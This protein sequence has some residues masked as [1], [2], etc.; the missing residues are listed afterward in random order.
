M[1]MQPSRRRVSLFG[2]VVMAA[3]SLVGAGV[4]PSRGEASEG[5]AAVQATTTPKPQSCAPG[6]RPETG[7]QGQVPPAD[8]HSGRSHNGYS[9]NLERIGG[10]S[11]ASFANFDSYRNCAYYT[12]NRGGSGM[13][14]GGGVVVDLSDPALPVKT[15]HLKAMAMGNGGESLRVN[16]ARGLLVSDH[17]NSLQT[18]PKASEYVHSLAVYDLTKDCRHPELLA[19]VVMPRAEGHEGCFQPDG[20]VYYMASTT[21]ITPIDLTDPRR[22]VELTAP[23]PLSIH[24]CS[25]SDDGRRGYFSDIGAARTLVVD[26]SEVQH[27]EPGAGYRII[28]TFDTPDNKIKQ[29]SHPLRYGDHQYLFDWSELTGNG[30]GGCRPGAASFGYASMVDIADETKPVEVSRLM[31]E[32][33]DPANCGLMATDRSPQT[34]GLEHGDVFFPAAAQLFTYD[35][36]YCRPDRLHEPTIM[37]CANFASGVRV[38]DIRDP[39]APKEI[40]Y[41]NTGTVP[42]PQPVAD[43]AASPPVIRRDLGQIWWVTLYG[44]LHV[45]Q[46]RPGVWPFAG[47]PAC[48]SPEDYFAVQYGSCSPPVQAA[49]APVAATPTTATRTAATPPA[50]PAAASAPAVTPA[51]VPAPVAAFPPPAN[52][53]FVFNCVVEAA[54]RG[55]WASPTGARA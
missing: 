33:H 2:V 43:F 39:A 35:F 1:S 30:F 24:G 21:T 10:F 29:S 53:G 26:T 22:P 28:S 31:L 5:Q 44:G 9:C 3:A 40:A 17:Y 52:G 37:A 6:D 47:D 38:F 36:H 15:A 51:A 34:A 18:N 12:D 14:E 27:R 11:S 32:V 25:I 49:A 50:G 16:Q 54:R 4:S 41:Y 46:F 48:P 42:G 45:A 8:R 55:V 23:W 20:M 7:L 13:A 19:D